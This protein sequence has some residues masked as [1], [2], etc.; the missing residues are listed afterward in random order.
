M[1]AIAIV[2]GMIRHT[3]KTAN[4]IAT[5]FPHGEGLN[6]QT[7]MGIRIQVL[8]DVKSALTGAA[9]IELENEAAKGHD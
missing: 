5:E 4:A 3:V 2:E 8:S 9:I 6:A 7:G 1:D